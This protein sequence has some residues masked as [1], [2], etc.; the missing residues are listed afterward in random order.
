VPGSTVPV[1]AG[2]PVMAPES[3]CG[4]VRNSRAESGGDPTRQTPDPTRN[5]RWKASRFKPAAVLA[6]PVIRG[7]EIACG[8]LPQEG[9]PSAVSG[10]SPVRQAGPLAP[11][12]PGMPGAQAHRRAASAPAAVGETR[13]N[14]PVHP[15][16]GEE[17]AAHLHQNQRMSQNSRAPGTAARQPPGNLPRPVPGGSGPRDAPAR[18]S[19]QR[20]R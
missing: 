10:C 18:T 3:R 1:T 13:P 4:P 14:R 7:K 6:G 2:L 17:T 8:S 12:Y 15:Q 9:L 19:R 20:G 16:E 5:C 11:V